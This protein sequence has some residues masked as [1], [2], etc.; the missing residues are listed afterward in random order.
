MR[1]ETSKRR[2]SKVEEDEKRTIDCKGI[3][4]K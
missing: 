2:E 4:L 3:L 1:G